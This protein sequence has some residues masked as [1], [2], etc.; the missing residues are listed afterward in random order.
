[1]YNVLIQYSWLWLKHFIKKL[2][3]AEKN[4]IINF[5]N[6]IHWQKHWEQPETQFSLHYNEILNSREQINV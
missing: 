2:K 4:F 1:M 3:T 5:I 6:L